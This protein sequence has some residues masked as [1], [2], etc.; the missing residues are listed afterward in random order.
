MCGRFEVNKKLVDKGVYRSLKID[1]ESINNLDQRPTQTVECLHHHQGNIAQTSSHWGI[2]P[3]WAH[4]PIINA[5]METVATKKTFS[6]AYALHRCVVP[7]SGWFEWTG[8]AGHKK[9]HRFASVE[10]NVLY[11]AGILFP[12]KQ[13]PNKQ[14]SHQVNLFQL[15]TITCEADAHCGIY[16]HRM[17]LLIDESKVSDWLSLPQS[18]QELSHFHDHHAIKI[19]PPI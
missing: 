12:Y 1:F 17:P 2:K 11:M 10:E 18:L 13:F 19:D 8:E 15:V 3:E 9:K 16:H 7:C 14:Q 5:Q 4:Y 6:S